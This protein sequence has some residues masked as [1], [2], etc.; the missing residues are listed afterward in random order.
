[1]EER[2][3]GVYE[4]LWDC[5]FCD[6]KGLLGKSQRHCANCGAK[7]N[8][9]KRYF[10]KPGEERRIDGHKFVG[11]DRTCPACASPQSAAATNCTNCGAP[12]DGAKEVKGVVKPVAPRPTTGKLS[13]ILVVLGVIVLVIFCI[14][15]FFIRTKET[16]LTVTQHRWE[17]AIG[18]EEYNDRSEQGWRNEVPRDADMVMCHQKERSTKQV[19]DGET[20][21]T[22]DVDNKDGTFK[23]VEKCTPKY[24]SEP[25]YDDYCDYHLRRWREVDSVIA[26]GTGMSPAWPTSG[27]PPS[28]AAQT[29]GAR[30]P[31][32]RSE[33]LILDFGSQ[34][35]DVDDAVWRKYAD[36]ASYKV[37]V[38]ARSNKIVCKSL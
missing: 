11:S 35:C 4:M 1:M 19:K 7:Q 8:P 27:L 23:R 10:P 36:N 3:E 22:E 31:G 2:V 25:V 14:W 29:L 26:K 21:H 13:R 17:R 34:S 28:T 32:K 5:E 20:C 9:D 6:T 18:I 37:E 24:R 33:K 15:Y 16:K 38:R 30:R 12:L